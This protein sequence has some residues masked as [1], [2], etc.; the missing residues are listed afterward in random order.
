MFLVWVFSRE[1]MFYQM[2]SLHNWRFHVFSFVLSNVR[3]IVLIDMLN[4]VCIL[5]KP[6][7]IV[8]CNPFK[9]CHVWFAGIWLSVFNI[10]SHKKCWPLVCFFCSLLMVW[11][12]VRLSYRWKLSPIN[13]K[14]TAKTM[15]EG[16]QTP[17]PECWS[18]VWHR[19]WKALATSVRPHTS[20]W[21]VFV[22][23]CPMGFYLNLRLGFMGGFLILW[24]R[25]AMAIHIERVKFEH[26]LFVERVLD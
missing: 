5:N 19:W 26:A 7:L 2:P 18:A 4:H 14:M 11:I 20:L 1:R 6:T 24:L 23:V 21:R 15:A 16:C 10:Y 22:K 9:H 3:C 12:M 17:A 8:V 13:G 25:F